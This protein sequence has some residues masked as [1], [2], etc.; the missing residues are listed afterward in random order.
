ME[1]VTDIGLVCLCRFFLP[2]AN[3]AKMLTVM[4][5]SFGRVRSRKEVWPRLGFLGQLRRV[6]IGRR[7]V[8]PDFGQNIASQLRFALPVPHAGIKSATRD[9]LAMGAAL[10]DRAAIEHQNLVGIDDR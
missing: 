2:A 9:Q 5:C 10:D 6:A 7:A 8:I 4:M 3:G 1:A